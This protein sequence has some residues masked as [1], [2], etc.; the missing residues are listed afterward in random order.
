M[1]IANFLEV[2]ELNRA[3]IESGQPGVPREELIRASDVTNKDA[4]LSA[5]IA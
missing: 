3:L 4:I 5:R 1:R 2:L